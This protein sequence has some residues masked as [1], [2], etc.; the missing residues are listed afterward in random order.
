MKGSTLAV[1]LIER[2]RIRVADLE[3]M[4]NVHKT[5]IEK[6]KNSLLITWAVCLEYILDRISQKP[7]MMF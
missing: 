6:L 5:E 2:L 3:S 7:L 1:E 4:E